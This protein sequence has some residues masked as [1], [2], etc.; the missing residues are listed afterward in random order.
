LKKV[1]SLDE[2]KGSQNSKITTANQANN[3]NESQINGGKQSQTEQIKGK[4]K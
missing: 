2:A 3:K 1:S 4:K